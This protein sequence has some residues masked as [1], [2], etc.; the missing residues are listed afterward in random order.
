[1]WVE[2]L[3]VGIILILL[4]IILFSGDGIARRRVLS[5][6]IDSLHKEIRRLQNANEALRSSMGVGSETRVKRFADLFELVRDLEALRCAIAGSSVC[7]R[8]LNKKY[9]TEPGPELLKRI[10]AARVWMDS[11][12]KSRLADELLVG[13]V[14]RN[15][16]RSLNSGAPID[17]AAS[18]AG[19]PVAVARGQVRRLQVLGYLDNRVALTDRGREAL[20]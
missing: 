20:I 5:R 16:L 15:I 11:A 7:Q 12:V 17:R 3:L 2:A 1:M 18:N 19:V 6:Q 13:E 14:G 9:G 4:G 10:L 8:M